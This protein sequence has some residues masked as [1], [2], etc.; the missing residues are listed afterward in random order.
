MLISREKKRLVEGN[1]RLRL[2]RTL[3]LSRYMKKIHSNS[4]RKVET[5][6]K[7]T[8]KRYTG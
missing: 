8:C 6:K 2:T 3:I 4:K 7:Y 1:M 5:S